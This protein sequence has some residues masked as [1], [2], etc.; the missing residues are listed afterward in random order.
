MEIN[1]ESESR[2]L[3]DGNYKKKVEKFSSFQAVNDESEILQNVGRK[4]RK[5]CA[6]FLFVLRN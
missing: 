1:T 5:V 4:I 6:D 2:Q 3:V